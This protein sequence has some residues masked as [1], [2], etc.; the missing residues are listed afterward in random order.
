MQ[1]QITCML[2]IFKYDCKLCLLEVYSGYALDNF[3]KLFND[4][5]RLNMTILNPYDMNGTVNS[6]GMA[7]SDDSEIIVEQ[8]IW[9]PLSNRLLNCY[10]IGLDTIK[11]TKFRELKT[12]TMNI[13]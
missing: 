3:R 10:Y 2:P 5:T 12:L 13:Y 6:I 7:D 4:N 11:E 9:T 8:E 1:Q